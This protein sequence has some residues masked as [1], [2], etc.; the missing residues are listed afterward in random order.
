MRRKGYSYADIGGALG[1]DAGAIWREVERNKTNGAYDPRKAARKAYVR[2]KYAKFQGMKIVARPALNAFV[3]ENLLKGQSPQ[4]ISGR[5]K[6]KREKGLSY[7]SKD[8]VYRYLVS[9]YGRRIEAAL[10]KK[11]KRRRKRAPRGTLDGRAFIDQRPAHINARLRVGHAELDFI[12]SGKQGRGIAATVVDRKLRVSFIEPIYHVS[13]PAVHAA[14]RTIK[15]RYGEWLTGTTDND[16]LFA[17]H[18][19]LEGELKIKIFFCHAY[20]S[21]EKGGVENVNGEIRKDVPRGSDLS[22]YSRT[23]WRMLE[24]KLNNRFMECLNYRTPT[25]ALALYRKRKK[26]RTQRSTKNKSDHC[27]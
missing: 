17:R 8:S 19:E 14:L 22:E 26:L 18:K 9:V 27:N 13:I 11:R 10:R 1:R 16:L 6:F 24:E 7:V 4:D 25:E 5:L 23:F 15:Q 12:V 3:D 21:W 20:S 2:K